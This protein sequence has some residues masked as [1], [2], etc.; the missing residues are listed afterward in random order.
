MLA[1]IASQVRVPTLARKV[2]TSAMPV[3]SATK[4]A[5][6]TGLRVVLVP[7]SGPCSVVK[8]TKNCDYTLGQEVKRAIGGDFDTCRFG[9]R[10]VFLVDPDSTMPA[11]EHLPKFK[12]SVILIHCKHNS[13]AFA[14]LD[15]NVNETNWSSLPSVNFDGRL[16]A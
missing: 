2:V 3:F 6:P 13:G 14:S 7:V 10:H 12:G 1:R 16:L 8:L 9:E 15:R 4:R 5:N 11:N